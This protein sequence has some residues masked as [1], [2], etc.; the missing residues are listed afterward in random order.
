VSLNF[1][2][3]TVATAPSPATSGTA[4]TVQ[5]GHGNRFYVGKAFIAPAGATP[6]PTNAEVVSITGVS[7]DTLTVTRGQESSTA[8]T[9]VVGD[10]IYQGIS[11]AMW[12][13]VAS[14]AN[15]SALTTL[16]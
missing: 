2:V 16:R 11:A 9:V 12:D 8:R 7:A 6:D 13:R 4:I 3:S 14:V 10:L 5:A 15:I 1:A